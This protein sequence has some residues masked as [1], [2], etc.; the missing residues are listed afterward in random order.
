MPDVRRM[1]RW[2]LWHVTAKNVVCQNMPAID[3]SAS[4]ENLLLEADELGLGAVWLGIAPLRDR[5]VK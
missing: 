4:V 5:M 1:H 3:L 2:H